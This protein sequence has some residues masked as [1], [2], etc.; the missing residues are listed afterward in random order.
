[1]A[2]YPATPVGH[3]FQ[4]SRYLESRMG[5]ILY[6][7]PLRSM[8]PQTTTQRPGRIN[9]ILNLHRRAG[10][11]S[12]IRHTNASAPK[13]GSC[14]H[15]S[16]AYAV[17]SKKPP[18][19]G[20]PLSSSNRQL[21]GGIR[22]LYTEFQK[23]SRNLHSELAIQAEQAKDYYVQIMHSM[24][25]TSSGSENCPRATPA[26]RRDSTPKHNRE[27]RLCRRPVLNS[28]KNTASIMTRWKPKDMRITINSSALYTN[29]W[30]E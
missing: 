3:L 27:Q 26:P 1:M 16:F 4:E 18:Q 30:K 15:A 10:T 21:Q 24:V 6:R 29:C 25:P 5:L 28:G 13:L 11:K 9:T 23:T 14:W 12:G 2:G 8:I 19:R 20:L 17:A 7:L 22:R